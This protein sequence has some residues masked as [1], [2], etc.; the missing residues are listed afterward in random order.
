MKRA[1]Q[2]FRF[3]AATLATIDQ[4]NE[5]I[6]EYAAQGFDLTLRQL[7]YQFVARDL[8]SNEERSYKKLG[9][10][11]ND[12]RLAGLIDWNAI[13]DRTRRLQ[14]Y[15]K[16]DSPASMIDDDVKVF[17]TDK[18]EDQANYV[19]VWIE[20][21][22]LVG[23]LESVCPELDVNYFSC[24]G[25]TSQSSMWRAAMRL[26][27]KQRVDSRH[28]IIFHLGDHDP[29][30]IDMSRDIEDRLAMFGV[31]PL[32]FE[33]IAL[34]MDQVEEYGPPPNPAKVTDSRFEAYRDEHGDESWELDA[35]DPSTL[36]AL[37]REKVSEVRDD[38]LWDEAVLRE[39]TMRSQLQR[40]ADN[41]ENVNH[42]L[43]ELE[44]ADD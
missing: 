8:V 23:V 11:V 41:F 43:D 44:E 24:R 36:V 32:G 15:R 25:Y 31:R 21:D 14:T 35:L 39:E 22:A 29:S 33:R 9:S 13:Q 17:Q 27:N 3:K 18:W 1:Y 26:R 5:I 10:I 40:I 34:N 20:K 38:D 16:W 28:P 2:E 6:E 37:I 4:A 42:Y 19:E 12:G 7:Y 30:G